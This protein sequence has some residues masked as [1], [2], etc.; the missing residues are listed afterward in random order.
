MFVIIEVDFIAN[1]DK[2]VDDNLGKIKHQADSVKDKIDQF[3][4]QIGSKVKSF[5]QA[6]K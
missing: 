4:N 6:M 3:V 1:V 5:G 2:M